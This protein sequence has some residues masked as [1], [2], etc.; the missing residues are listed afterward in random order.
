MIV[1]GERVWTLE[2]NPRFT[3]S[4]EIVERATGVNAIAAHAAACA[5]GIGIA[6]SKRNKDIISPHAYGKAILFGRRDLT[7]SG[8]FAEWTLAEA[9]RTPWPTLADIS[10]AGTL[11][12]E[13]RPVLT[14]FA[15]GASVD[16]VEHKLRERVAE[17]ERKLYAD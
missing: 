3:A 5:E 17:L 10:P 14:V 7:I 11:I 6:I 16:E 2:V 8:K 15:D 4:V 12:E 9:L 13:G 1:D